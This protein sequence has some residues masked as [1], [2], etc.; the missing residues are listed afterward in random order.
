MARYCLPDLL[1]IA[2][3]C[4]EAVLGCRPVLLDGGVDVLPLR[5]ALRWGRREMLQLAE[6]LEEELGIALQPRDE[7]RLL[8][9]DVTLTDV[10]R[11]CAELLARQDAT[12]P[13]RAPAPIAILG[14]LRHG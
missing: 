4:A 9:P 6:L 7:M 3:D 12:W 14:V 2:R 1:A 10:A 13:A 5:G 11:L 8:G